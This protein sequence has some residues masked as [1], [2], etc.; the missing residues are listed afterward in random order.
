MPVLHQAM[1]T[2]KADHSSLRHVW[3]KYKDKVPD[4]S[5]SSQNIETPCKSKL[6]LTEL[7]DLFSKVQ[8]R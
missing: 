7:K 3:A 1:C 2:S 4:V 5:E 6:K 8:K